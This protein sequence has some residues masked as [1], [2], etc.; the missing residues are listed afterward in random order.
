MLSVFDQGQMREHKDPCGGEKTWVDPRGSSLVWISRRAGGG[1][2]NDVNRLNFPRGNR[3][4]V[5]CGFFVL[6]DLYKRNVIA[7]L[8]IS[9]DASPHLFPHV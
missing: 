6:E 2:L 3:P 7:D 9:A 4:Q 8:L 5:R 1:I